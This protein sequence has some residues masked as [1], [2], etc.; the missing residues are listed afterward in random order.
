MKWNPHHNNSNF[1]PEVRVS[2]LWLSLSNVASTPWSTSI[3]DSPP[4]A[5]RFGLVELLVV[6]ASYSTE[7]IRKVLTRLI[8]EGRPWLLMYLPTLFIVRVLFN[9]MFLMPS[10]LWVNLVTWI[11]SLNV[12]E[13]WSCVIV[14]SWL[15]CDHWEESFWF[16]IYSVKLSC[17]NASLRHRVEWQ[18]VF[19][20]KLKVYVGLFHHQHFFPVFCY[21]EW[22]ISNLL[23]TLQE[24]QSVFTTPWI[25]QMTKTTIGVHSGRAVVI[26]WTCSFDIYW[27]DCPQSW[28]FIVIE[29]QVRIVCGDLFSPICTVAA[30]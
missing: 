6:P 3:R 27:H 19:V 20:E 25:F 8:V 21:I 9:Q 17:M 16:C 7:P 23:W 22:K 14:W 29:K 28:G 10:L 2:F 12:T 11:R 24:R 15:G 26:D 5:P 18:T 30:W 1:A 4:L 13:L